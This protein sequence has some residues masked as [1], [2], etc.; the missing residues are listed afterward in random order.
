MKIKFFGGAGG[1]TGSKT[2][3]SLGKEK[4]LVDYGLYQGSA[5]RRE[6]NWENF[7][8]ARKISAVFLTHAHIDH[9]GL[10][11][12][13]RK[14]GFRGHV[15]CSFE[16]YKL[17]EILLE[18]S[19][20]IHEE[21]AKFAN[22]KDYSRHKPA[23]PVYTQKDAAEILKQFKPVNFDEEI[24]ISKNLSITFF[25]AGHIIGASFIK[26]KFTEKNESEKVIVFS[27]DVGH[28]RNIL[29]NPPQLLCKMDFLVLESTYGGKLHPRIPAKEVLGLYLN[30][31]LKKSGVAILPSFSVGRTQDVLYLIK[32]LMDEK[33]IPT[34][35]VYLDSP[36]SKKANKI[37]NQCFKEDCVKEEVLQGGDIYPASLV[38]IDSVFESKRLTTAE[39]PLIIIS[40]S[41]MID[42]GRVIHHIKK[43]I[44]NKKNGIILV[45]YQPEGTKGR[46]LIDGVK[47]LRLH[48]QEFSIEANIFHINS[49]SAHGDYLDMIEWIK[50][51]KI[52]PKLV[53][54]NHGEESGSKH[55]KNL[56]ESQL[57]F[58][59]TVADFGEEFD[60]QHIF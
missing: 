39:G 50:E 14:D 42:G 51:S 13:L 57:D 8:E 46:L 22:E 58:K 45:G 12:R 4:Y 23:L 16:T 26:I 44:S 41:G 55:M 21:D 19:A 32:K 36:L 48:K 25:W 54:L 3:L 24:I 20:K 31:I 47:M 2:L 59:T 52:N 5:E 11:P 37:F 7:A 10:L 56:I 15:Y 28:K 9:S 29:L 34:V 40:A 1:V 6:R 30:A 35:P 43:R 33:V 18:D 53:I 49:L 60:L 38:E 17:C 27:G